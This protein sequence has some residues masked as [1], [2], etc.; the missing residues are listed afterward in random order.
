MNYNNDTQVG[1]INNTVI[2]MKPIYIDNEYHGSI[3]QLF[4]FSNL[5]FFNNVNYIDS[6]SRDIILDSKTNRVIFDP[7]AQISPIYSI[8]NG[9]IKYFPQLQPVVFNHSELQFQYTSSVRTSSVQLYEYINNEIFI[10]KDA[11]LYQ[12]KNV[13]GKYAGIISISNRA[14]TMKLRSPFT[15]CNQTDIQLVILKQQYIQYQ[16]QRNFDVKELRSI[17]SPSHVKINNEC[18]QKI[19]FQ[20]V[21]EASKYY[22][23]RKIVQ[24]TF[25]V[26]ISQCQ[27]NQSSYFNFHVGMEILIDQIENNQSNYSLITGN[28]TKMIKL[29]RQSYL[30]A[31]QGENGKLQYSFIQYLNVPQTMT[32]HFLNQRLLKKDQSDYQDVEYDEIIDQNTQTVIPMLIYDIMYVLNDIALFSQAT[33]NLQNV[34]TNYNVLEVQIGHIYYDQKDITI[35]NLYMN[36]YTDYKS[37][38]NITLLC[39]ARFKLFTDILSYYQ[40]HYF[41]YSSGP[42]WKTIMQEQLKTQPQGQTQKYRI[43]QIN[44][45]VAITKA[46]L[47]N[48]KN[49]DNQTGVN[50]FLTIVLNKSFDLG[51]L[52]LHTYF[53]GNLRYISGIEEDLYQNGVKL[54]LSSYKYIQ[55]IRINQSVNQFN[56]IYEINHN[57]WDDAFNKAYN[58]FVVIVSQGKNVFE[59]YLNLANYNESEMH[60]RT[61]IFDA[62]SIYFSSGKVIVKQFGAID[63]I[64]VIYD[65]IIL[66]SQ[67]DII[68]QLHD[69]NAKQY[70]NT[71]NI[72]QLEHFYFNLTQRVTKSVQTITRKLPNNYNPSGIIQYTTKEYII[73]LFSYSIPIIII[74]LIIIL[75]Q[76]NYISFSQNI[77][78]QL[79]QN[80]I[81]SGLNSRTCSVSQLL[82]LNSSVKH[83]FNLV[84]HNLYMH[85]VKKL[86]QSLV[87]NN[88]VFQQDIQDMA[89]L[90]QIINSLKYPYILFKHA[91]NKIST[92]MLPF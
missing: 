49:L 15:S 56:D 54:I 82:Q 2:F 50:G 71:F 28:L 24:S 90:S 53:D 47:V 84:D 30:L 36:Y 5:F 31:G 83:N 60:E 85:K 22:M 40:M 73:V 12:L 62:K 11:T 26:P 72:S 23:A 55:S 67:F 21:D 7:F 19:N 79:Y 16:S 65:N 48:N 34:V 69:L 86:S 10:R 13:I 80:D 38:N 76:Q 8:I 81:I 43:G 70:I 29:M 44:G 42:N 37:Q 64:L 51:I 6:I 77:Y 46:L 74:S 20:C 35:H 45:N 17:A 32:V 87:M 14:L 89:A 52:E 4:E 25:D 18:P 68:R 3:Y 91:F 27:F 39:E 1:T 33:Y 9:I 58:E 41:T 78:H 88:W 92:Q 59:N 61:V 57:F 66:N 75:K 63:G